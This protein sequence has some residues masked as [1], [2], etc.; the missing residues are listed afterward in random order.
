MP[1]YFSPRD[2]NKQEKCTSSTSTPSE[3][4][5]PM[6]KRNMQLAIFTWF[7]NPLIL[8]ILEENTVVRIH[9]LSM[10]KQTWKNTFPLTPTLDNMSSVFLAPLSLKLKWINHIK[11]IYQKIKKNTSQI[12]A[13]YS[14][15]SIHS[16]SFFEHFLV[17]C[18][19][20]C[21]LCRSYSVSPFSF[22]SQN[23]QPSC[24]GHCNHH[25]LLEQSH[26]ILIK[27]NKRQN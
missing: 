14:I 23:H 7:P 19:L 11:M 24:H 18:S 5:L 20:Q 10:R 17:A 13:N 15:K 3:K 27:E 4:L 6:R 16:W 2:N 25:H 21:V 22:T 8:F 12:L 1:L 9:P 26:D